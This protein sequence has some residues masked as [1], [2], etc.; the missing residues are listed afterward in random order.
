MYMVDI[1]NA[2]DIPFSS[3]DLKL[4]LHKLSPQQVVYHHT[5]LL[6]MVFIYTI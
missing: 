6:T 2:V 3:T 5:H 1:P 4:C